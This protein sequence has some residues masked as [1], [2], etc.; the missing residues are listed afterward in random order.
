MAH[1]SYPIS[2]DDIYKAYEDCRKKKKSKRG[3]VSFESY[4]L[5]NCVKLVEEINGRTYKLRRS[6]CFIIDYPTPREVFCAS[7]RDRVVQHFVY[8]EINPV[9]ERMLVEDT[10]SCRLN[11][12]TDYAIKREIRKLRQ[13]SD[14]YKKEVWIQKIDLSGFFMSIDRR[15]LCDKILD[16]VRTRY[17]G[18]YTSTLEYL[19]PII[20]LSDVTKDTVRLCSAS[21]WSRLPQ[22]KTLFGNTKGLAIGNITSQLFANFALNDIDHFIKSRHKGYVRYVDDMV[23]IDTD[24]AKLKETKGIVEKMLDAQG[25][26]INKKKSILQKGKFGVPFLGVIV[27]PY[28][29]VLGRQRIS[30]I[31]KAKREFKDPYNA[32]QS[33]ATRKGMFVRY[34]GIRVAHRWFNSIPLSVRKDIRMNMDTSTVWLGHSQDVKLNKGGLLCID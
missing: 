16:V 11:K 8:N 29:A 1:E 7:F 15:W 12:G 27:K 30:R 21:K 23:I 22:R 4:A 10:C 20:I 34:H 19:I 2:I 6:E 26:R 28:Y 17:R 24:R 3:T 18:R 9:I 33:I 5:F 13:I 32:Y 25:M 31:Y 14:N